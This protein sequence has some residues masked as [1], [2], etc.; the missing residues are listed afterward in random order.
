MKKDLENI[1]WN[2]A[3]DGKLEKV[4]NPNILVIS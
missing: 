1:N 3:L 4:T 2:R